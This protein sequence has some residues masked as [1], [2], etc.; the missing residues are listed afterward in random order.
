MA[1]REAY[2]AYCTPAV[3][4]H[5]LRVACEWGAAN[6]PGGFQAFREIGA[7]ELSFRTCL[8]A[9][10]LQRD[11]NW[12]SR[13]ERKKLFGKFNNTLPAEKAKVIY[14]GQLNA[15]SDLINEEQTAMLN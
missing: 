2:H 7:F 13:A 1:T 9:G 11:A 10:T 5:S 3:E 14:F 6:L 8:N 12:L 15:Y 4:D